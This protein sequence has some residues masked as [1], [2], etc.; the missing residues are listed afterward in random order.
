MFYSHAHM[1]EW[2]YVHFWLKESSQKGVFYFIFI[3]ESSGAYLGTQVMSLVGCPLT[4]GV[5]ALIQ[6]TVSHNVGLGV[7]IE[8][9]AGKDLI[10]DSPKKY[11]ASYFVF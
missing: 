3:G 1:V 5:F 11:F 9:V 8:K 4:S 6:D 10:L 7:E 2:L